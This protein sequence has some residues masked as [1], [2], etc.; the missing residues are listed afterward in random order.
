MSITYKGDQLIA[1][2]LQRNSNISTV[3]I[4]PLNMTSGKQGLLRS[5]MT[6]KALQRCIAHAHSLCNSHWFTYNLGQ[7]LVLKWNVLVRNQLGVRGIF[8]ETWKLHKQSAYEITVFKRSPC[9]KR[10]STK[11]IE[12]V[13]KGCV[14]HKR[15]QKMQNDLL[16]K[17]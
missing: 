12:K 8:K 15:I 11:T 1:L 6:S 10:S 4:F 3:Q 17:I 14:F 9:S 7:T 16:S 5:A 2:N 13:V